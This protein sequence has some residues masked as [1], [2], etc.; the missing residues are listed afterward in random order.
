MILRRGFTLIELLVVITIMILLAGMTYA[1]ANAFIERSRRDRAAQIASTL[2]TA[3]AQYRPDTLFVDITA[4]NPT[5]IAITL[6]DANNDGILD[7]DPQKDPDFNNLLRTRCT[8]ARYAGAWAA[9]PNLGK[10]DPTT[11]RVLDPWN[12]PYQITRALAAYGGRRNVWSLG[13]DGMP[14]TGDDVRGAARKNNP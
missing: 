4:A 12:R 7:G 14:W 11:G 5:G 13:A 6:F 3:I 9:L 10:R 8:L 1:G 2:E